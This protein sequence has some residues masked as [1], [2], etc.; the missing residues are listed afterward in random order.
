MICSLG[1]A[2]FPHRRNTFNPRSEEITAVTGDLYETPSPTTI[3]IQNDLIRHSSFINL[4]ASYSMSRDQESALGLVKI[5]EKSVSFE[6][7]L[8]LTPFVYYW[9]LYYVRV[10]VK[11]MDWKSASSSKKAISSFDHVVGIFMNHEA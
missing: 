5:V 2:L 11:L 4:S 9:L 3:M 8:M 10:Q 7:L 1:A 6:M